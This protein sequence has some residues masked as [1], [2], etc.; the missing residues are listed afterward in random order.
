MLAIVTNFGRS[1][2][3]PCSLGNLWLNRLAPVE[4]KN[5]KAIEELKKYNERR[6]IQLEIKMIDDPLYP[7]KKAAMDIP[8]GDYSKFDEFKMDYSQFKIQQLRSMA[9]AKGIE[10]TFKMT[11]KLLIEKLEEKDGISKSVR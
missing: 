1:R 3:F 2:I 6:D 4:I 7:G 11:K 5:L 8:A 9:V 10:K